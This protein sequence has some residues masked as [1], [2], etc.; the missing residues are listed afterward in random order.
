MKS[1][2]TNKKILITGGTGSFGSYFVKEILKLDPK[3]IIIFSRDEDKQYSMQ[4]EF[5]KYRN[6]LVFVLGDVRDVNSLK[7]AF[8]YMPDFVIHAAALKQIPSSEYN[9]FETVKTNVLGA[10]NIVELCK[11]GKVKKVLSI[12]TDKAVEPVNVMGMTK[13]LQERIF[14]LANRNSKTKFASVRYGNV[15][16]SRGSII[17][18][19]KKQIAAGGP[20]TITDLQMTRFIL[21]LRQTI[22]LVTFAFENMNGGEIFVPN[23]KALKIS[24]LGSVMVNALKSK[25]KK[26]IEVGVRPGEKLH[27]TLISRPESLRVIKSKSFYTILPQIEL[28]KVTKNGSYSKNKSFVFAS[29]DTQ[30]FKPEEIKEMLIKEDII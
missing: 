24:D 21:T 27:E 23:V 30:L 4:F 6:K 25:N 10:Q 22:G 11:T 12:S 26:I 8:E 15:I 2:F 1:V 18:L 14:T 13:A 19:F 9:I 20:I 17:P 28:G 5:S 16:N 29:Q 7:K 3:L